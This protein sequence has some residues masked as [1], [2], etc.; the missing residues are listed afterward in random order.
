MLLAE[1]ARGYSPA[2]VSWTA[3]RGEGLY[4]NDKS[5][6]CLANKVNL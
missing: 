1:K 2:A 5:F 3:Q 6:S 4:D